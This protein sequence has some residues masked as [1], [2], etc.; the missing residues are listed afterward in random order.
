MPWSQIARATASSRIAR[1]TAALSLA[2]LA[3]TACT[4]TT[5]TPTVEQTQTQT[6]YLNPELA[7]RA[8]EPLSEATVT[9]EATRLADALAALIDVSTVVAVTDESQLIAADD[10]IAAYYVAFRT[11]TLD[12]SADLQTLAEA[13]G[14][15]LAHSGWTKHGTSNED[16]VLIVRLTGGTDE[17]PWFMFV[18][19]E[20][21]VEGQPAL[22]IQ[23]AGPDL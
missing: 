6:T 14:A 23:I 15:V 9:G 18:Q 1:A 19:G 5:P 11:Y 13:L 21:A 10:D 22:S 12:P 8:L 2:A 20:T 7:P 17:Q 16:G 3:L 4:S